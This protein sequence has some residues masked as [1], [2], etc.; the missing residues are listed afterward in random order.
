M[1]TNPLHG[2][3]LL[4]GFMYTAYGVDQYL[5]NHLSYKTF[6]VILLVSQFPSGCFLSFFK[7]VLIILERAHTAQF[8]FRM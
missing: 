1:A 3:S 2:N 4:L 5:K 7:T 8:W 6:G